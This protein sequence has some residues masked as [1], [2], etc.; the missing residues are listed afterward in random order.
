LVLALVGITP[1]GVGFGGPGV[2]ADGLGAV[3]DDLVEIETVARKVGSVALLESE[4]PRF[5]A[6][7]LRLPGR[8]SSR[9]SEWATRLIAPGFPAKHQASKPTFLATVS[10]NRPCPNTHQPGRRRPWRTRGR[11]GW[12][13][14]SR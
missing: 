3:G 5:R 2:E 12:P 7:R 1:V 11:D 8:N 14:C 10:R 6:S 4:S 13:R 9:T